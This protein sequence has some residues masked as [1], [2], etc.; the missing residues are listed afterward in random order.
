MSWKIAINIEYNRDKN[1]C[2]DLEE[3]FQS[4]GSIETDWENGEEG[5][6][7][8]RS[9]WGICDLLTDLWFS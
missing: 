3:G 7:E 9:S 8:E 5:A 2:L 6:R 1:L 4:E